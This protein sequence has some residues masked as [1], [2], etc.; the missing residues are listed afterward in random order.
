MDEAVAC[1]GINL[2]CRARSYERYFIRIGICQT[3][4]RIVQFVQ[5]EV[6]YERHTLQNPIFIS[7]EERMVEFELVARTTR[8]MCRYY[9]T[10]AKS[11][12]NQYTHIKRVKSNSA[13][14][15]K[16][17]SMLFLVLSSVGEHIL[18]LLFSATVHNVVDRSVTCVLIAA[19]TFR[20]LTEKFH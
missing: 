6:V 7:A 18:N 1:K 3:D 14:Y 16:T 20:M 5:T 10:R 8:R 12:T 17:N 15:M 19:I 13:R 11:N 9:S 4:V 2:K